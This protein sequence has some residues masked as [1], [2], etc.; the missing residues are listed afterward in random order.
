MNYTDARAFVINF[1]GENSRD[2][3]G[4]YREAMSN[5]C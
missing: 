2:G 3:G 5:I 4:P 1:K